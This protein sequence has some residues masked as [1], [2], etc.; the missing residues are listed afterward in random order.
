MSANDLFCNLNLDRYSNDPEEEENVYESDDPKAVAKETP[1]ILVSTER[2]DDSDT[3]QTEFAA[4][5]N[6][7]GG[8]L[9]KVA[10]VKTPANTPAKAPTEGDEDTKKEFSDHLARQG[11][12]KP[13]RPKAKALN[14]QETK[15][16]NGGTS[17]K[18]HDTVVMQTD[19]GHG[20]KV[21][22]A[23]T[24]PADHVAGKKGEHA[25]VKI[26][27]KVPGEAAVKAPPEQKAK[28]PEKAEVKSPNEATMKVSGEEKPKPNQLESI[29]YTKATTVVNAAGATEA[30]KDTEI[31]ER[32]PGW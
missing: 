27:E 17:K 21:D 31:P 7:Q 4:H 9:K 12:K 29:D 18:S 1:K 2:I 11:A 32:K 30:N 26:G 8:K 28:K 23:P 15:P 22:D 14:K 10:P 13:D 19:H 5:M 24:M 16:T 6:R 20:K 3:S 25:V